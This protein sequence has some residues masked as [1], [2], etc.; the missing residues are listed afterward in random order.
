MGA[1]VITIDCNY[2]LPRFAAA[3]LITDGQQAAF[4]DNNTTHAVPF[5][6]KALAATHRTPED[7]QWIIITHVHLDHAGGT[8]RLAELCP[9]ARV[10]AHPKAAKHVIDP[11]R[12]VSSARR[13][14][15]DD[16]FEQLY[17]AIRPVPA[18]RVRPVNDGETIALGT[19]PLRFLYTRGHAN[20]HFCI[21]DERTSSIFTGDSFGL[22]YP[23]L[24]TQG[25]FVF[26]TT[27]PT[28]FDAKEALLTLDR[29]QETGARTAYPTHF[30]A[31]ADLPAARAQL[32]E[33]LRFS[34][35]LQQRAFERIQ[36]GSDAEL[37][38]WCEGELRAHYE[39]WLQN[40]R[41]SFDQDQ[42]ELLSMDL[43]LN[44]DGIAIAA[45]RQL[46]EHQK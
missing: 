44:G 33:H 18:E 13:V 42:W 2:V 45:R 21:F 23:A 22:S 9:N 36:A 32:T 31:I 5:L 8:S 20:H 4:I 27:S 15:G 3:Y 39:A 35:D 34:G 10:L 6:L 28:D 37:G 12:L 38:R 1:E 40:H 26:P 17:G 11:E 29:I 14:Y 16:V 25:L 19:R 7:V 30:G 43:R 41:M 46:E 24:Q